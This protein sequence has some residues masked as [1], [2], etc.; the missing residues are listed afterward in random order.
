MRAKWLWARGM[1]GGR[2]KSLSWHDLCTP[3]RWHGSCIAF[4]RD[5][6]ALA[7]SLL[8]ARMSRVA[9]VTRTR[10]HFRADR[11]LHVRAL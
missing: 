5:S 4:A 8:A 2:V 1:G 10:F 7:R 3:E 6:D 11:A 9:R